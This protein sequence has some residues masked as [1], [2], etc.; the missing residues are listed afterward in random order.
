M[1]GELFVAPC[2]TYADGTKVRLQKLAVYLDYKLDESYT[3]NKMSIR[4][5][6]SIH[7]LKEIKLVELTDPVGWVQIPLQPP[8]ST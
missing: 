6:T 7:D 2:L 4:A 5:G 8:S 1:S 3:P